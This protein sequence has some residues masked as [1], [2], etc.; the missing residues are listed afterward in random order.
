MPRRIVLLV[1]LLFVSLP[2]AG[3][4]AGTATAGASGRSV[5]LPGHTLAALAGATKLDD[6]QQAAAAAPSPVDQPLTL[7]VLLKRSDQAGFDR[8]LA[9]VEGSPGARSQPYLSQS[10]LADRFGPGQGVYD[11]VLAWFQRQ[12]FALVQGSENRLTLTLRG[13]RGQAARALQ[14]G[15]DAYR[16][17]GRTFFANDRDPQLP[18]SIAGYVQSIGGLS[19]L[20]TPSP[21]GA[22]SLKAVEQ[23]EEEVAQKGKEV[24][25]GQLALSCYLVEELELDFLAA[26][27]ANSLVAKAADA[28]AAE[29]ANSVTFAMVED[30]LR[31]KCAADELNLVAAYASS[32]G[33]A[34]AARSLAKVRAAPLAAASVS[35]AGQK[36]GLLE[37]DNF[38]PSDVQSYLT[39]IGE[40]ASFANLSQ[41]HVAGGAG[42]PGPDESEV[43][44]DIDAALSVAPGAQVVVYD[45]PF[46]GAGSFQT[47]LNAM[48]SDR[49]TVISSS[50]AYCEDQT[51]AA[52]VQAIDTILQNAA[53][54]GVTVLNGA[55]DRGS[56]CLDGSPNTLHVPADAP[57][58]T[59]VGG[60]SMTPGPAGTYASETWWDGSAAAPPTGQGGF[61]TSRFFTRP[62][63]Q[64]GLVSSP[65]RSVPDLALPAD[66][67][68]GYLICQADAGGCPAP[69]LFGGTSV[70][71]PIMAG[72]VAV[73]NQAQGSNLGFLNPLIYPLANS[74]AFHSAA[75]MGTDFAHVGLG[76]P[77]VDALY[78]ALTRQTAG[79][80]D[81]SVSGVRVSPGHV[82][83]DGIAKATVAVPVLDSKGNTIA[84]QTVVL[85]ANA[86]S[87]AVITPVN[88]TTTADNGTAIFAIT[89]TTLESVTLSATAGGTPI[90]E[91]ATVQFISPPAAAGGVT[92]SP[93][94]VPPDGTS[95]TTITVTLH[96]ARGNGVSGKTVT[97]SQNGGNSIVTGPTP[98]TTDTNGQVRFS[99]TDT[100]AENV[101]YTA[102]DVTDGNVPVPGSATVSFVST[103]SNRCNTGLG[104]AAA[105]YT[106]STFAGGFPMNGSTCIGADG[107]TFDTGGNLLV[108]DPTTGF[109]FR[110][111]PSGGTADGSMQVN[112]TAISGRLTGLA[113][114]RDGR[115]YGALYRDCDIFGCGSIV[116]LDPQTGTILR[117]VAGA[118]DSPALAIDPI[119]GDLFFTEAQQFQTSALAR[120]SNP[121]SATPT[122]TQYEFN[123][124]GL[125]GR[126]DGLTFASDG[127]LYVKSD[128]YTDIVTNYAAIF[129]VDGTNS[130]TPG[131]FTQL[132]PAFWAPIST[133]DGI[134]LQ[135][136]PASPSNPFLYVAR[137]NGIIT[138]LDTTTSPPTPT[139]IYTGGSRGDLVVVGPDACLY[140]DMSDRVLKLTNGDGSCSF[141]Q[142]I[143]QP[144]LALSPVTVAPNPTQGGSQ[145][146]TAK[147]T[148][149][150]TV[151]GVPVT[152]YVVGANAT[153]GQALTAADGSVSF[154]Y[155]GQYSGSDVVVAVTT[156]NGRQLLSN[157]TTLTWNSGPHTTFVDLNRSQSSGTTG[158]P[159]ALSASLWD[160]SNVPATPLGGVSLAFSMG[161]QSCTGTTDPT[162]SASCTVT[163]GT[164]G[165][166]T[167]QA[168]FAGSTQYL[169]S[170][171]TQAFLLSRQPLAS[172][173]LSTTLSAASVAA[174][175]AVH[176]SATLSGAAG[177]ASGSVTYNVYSGASC[178]GTPAFTNTV[179]LSTTAA[180]P[181]SAAFTPTTPGTYNWQA[182][183]GGDSNNSAAQSACGSETLT[184]TQATTT[185]TT[186][187]TAGSQ[188]GATLTVPAGTSVSDQATLGGVTTGA[189][190]T[191]IYTVYT[192][193]GCTKPLAGSASTVAVTNGNAPASS[194]VTFNTAGTYYWQAVYSGDNANAGA[195]SACSSEVLTVT[196]AASGPGCTVQ[197]VSGGDRNGEGGNGNRGDDRN[198]GRAA[199]VTV[200]DAAGVATITIFRTAD[201]DAKVTIPRF[202][203]GTTAPIVVRVERQSGQDDARVTLK[204]TNARGGTAFCSLL[205][206]TPTKPRSDDNREGDSR[207][208]DNNRPGDSQRDDGASQ[209]V[210]VL[211]HLDGSE[212]SVQVLP[213]KGLQRIELVVNGKRFVLDGL[214]DGKP[215]TVDISS[216]LKPGTDNTVTVTSFGDAGSSADLLLS[217]GT[218]TP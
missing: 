69:L 18:D 101:Q 159:A 160:V 158:Q 38:R 182:V 85:T 71:T 80:V 119:S 124:T 192:D 120:I 84:G 90:V 28:D 9:Q 189:G 200:K 47:M 187:L 152:F 173:T 25:E 58:G 79:P 210:D 89:D 207:R 214:G 213:G 62:S 150:A 178:T 23:W 52:D 217:N 208:D 138:K 6:A 212:G 139:D 10:E 59:A 154:S 44:L 53:A 215:R 149:V 60:T 183:Y 148:N 140:A 65:N 103:A 87:H 2:L 11:S 77:N 122:V 204:I 134:A 198:D 181:D 3:R 39:L 170:S 117:T 216:A 105:G 151:A 76:S 14:V 191:L 156:A 130:P 30:I 22:G 123:N 86:G 179:T 133:A 111:G 56:A 41:V 88:V 211:H 74:G 83:G 64:N 29:L 1:A 146:F 132:T 93:T 136:N 78:L 32:A 104:T 118:A 188:S 70:A 17:G 129:K 24:Q 40:P 21:V 26:E 13:T 113:M 95:T 115:L 142:P 54:A 73:M 61:G 127:T 180:V 203:P 8:Y 31:Y 48:L 163:P 116:E 37:F 34:G 175:T 218:G 46:T 190:G 110:F 19:N 102:V 97:L 16:A 72:I 50:W 5:R 91:T 135:P 206:S 195:T 96:D 141:S 137:N 194:A 55:G 75:S 92:A 167:L 168:S 145:T 202:T 196:A 161:G 36:I 94:T 106:V 193:N 153:L 33:S 51:T 172:P 82:I 177:T 108:G 49:D 147:L 81:G 199:T 42:A 185:A 68:N 109:I 128:I 35:G 99:A 4:A 107:L 174:S 165:S 67:A 112:Q 169:R 171:G 12:G 155:T 201:A 100:T 27:N 125:P 63:W 45:G 166:A 209:S 43:L 15:I 98:P 157:S 57:H 184:V 66:P 162:G 176:D 20:A 7:T 121:S 197:V 205:L 144:H 126:A 186:K 114:T 143:P 164:V 131:A